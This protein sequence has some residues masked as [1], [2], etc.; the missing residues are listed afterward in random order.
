ME[1]R[2]CSD[3]LV[4]M[5]GALIQDDRCPYKGQCEHRPVQSEGD[6]KGGMAIC[7]ARREALGEAW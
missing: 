5:K 6:V 1:I 3:N 4:K 2:F 7:E